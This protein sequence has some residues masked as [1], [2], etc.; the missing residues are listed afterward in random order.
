MRAFLILAGQL[1]QACTFLQTQNLRHPSLLL[2]I[3]RNPL[4]GNGIGMAKVP[5]RTSHAMRHKRELGEAARTNRSISATWPQRQLHISARDS[6]VERQLPRARGRGRGRGPSRQL[7][8][9]PNK[10]RKIPSPLKAASFTPRAA[11]GSQINLAGSANRCARSASATGLSSLR[12]WPGGPVCAAR[13]HRRR[14]R[15]ASPSAAGSGD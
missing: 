11:N 1:H 2:E 13:R 14:I 15:C 9:K 3:V 4:I 7:F 6:D 5:T 8:L 10:T 12:R